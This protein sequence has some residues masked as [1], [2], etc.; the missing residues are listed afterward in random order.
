MI[1]NSQQNNQAAGKMLRVVALVAALACASAF[2]A[3]GILPMAKRSTKSISG[4]S[5]FDPRNTPPQKSIS[6]SVSRHSKKI[7]ALCRLL[8]GHRGTIIMSVADKI[9]GDKLRIWNRRAVHAPNFTWTSSARRSRATMVFFHR[10]M[11][12]LLCKCVAAHPS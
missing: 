2:T 6:I 1:A 9:N 5:R 11:T 3:P 8:R 10:A 12:S 7:I 4:L